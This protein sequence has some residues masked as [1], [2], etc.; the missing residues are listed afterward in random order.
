MAFFRYSYYI[1][2]IKFALSVVLRSWY[3]DLVFFILFFQNAS[4]VLILN[5][6]EKIGLGIFLYLAFKEN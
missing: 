5:F 6:I 2:I 4:S 1:F 3:R